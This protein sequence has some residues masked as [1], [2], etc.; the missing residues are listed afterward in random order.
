MRTT[1]AIDDPLL[2]AAKERATFQKI[3]LSA[4]LEDAL[5]AHLMKTDP[6]LPRE[7]FRLITVKGALVDPTLDL[8]RPSALLAADDEASYREPR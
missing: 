2:A 7:P 6:A 3:T 5:R 8:D 4:L 1:V